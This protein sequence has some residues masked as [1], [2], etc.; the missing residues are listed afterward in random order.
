LPSGTLLPPVVPSFC[1][2]NR[3]QLVEQWDLRKL[4]ATA[5]TAMRRRGQTLTEQ[6]KDFYHGLYERT[7]EARSKA[8]RDGEIRRLRRSV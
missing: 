1:Q 3:G 2:V 5:A 8:I 6:H 4:L 7:A